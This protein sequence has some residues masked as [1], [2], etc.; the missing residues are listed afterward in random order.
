MKKNEELTLREHLQA[1]QSAGGKARW[2]G[3]TPEERSMAARK[4]VQA[5]WATKKAQDSTLSAENEPT[6]KA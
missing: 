2:A 4:A 1:I 3:L 6:Q 5:R